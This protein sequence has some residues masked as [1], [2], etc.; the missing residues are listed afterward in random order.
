MDNQFFDLKAIGRRIRGLRSDNG[1]SRDSFAKEI[2]SFSVASVRRWESGQ[3]AP[4][5]AAV[6]AICNRFNVSADEIVLGFSS[7]ETH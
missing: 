4:S 6:V 5:L 1:L 2:G 3:S 7:R